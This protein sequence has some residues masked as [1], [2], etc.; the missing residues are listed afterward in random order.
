MSISLQFG[1][2]LI[3]SA[4]I[5]ALAYRRGALSTSGVIGAVVVG[6]AIFGFGGWVWGL[7]L[8]A[9]FVLSS[10]LSHYRM[11]EKARLAAD[12]FEKGSARDIWQALANGGAGALIAAAYALWQPDP[13][14]LAAFVGAMASVN[15]D[16]WATELGVLSRRPPRRITT[17][18]PVEAGASGGVS[19]L[20]TLA[21]LGGALTIG[22]SA[23]LLLVLD[24]LLG[25]R[26]LATAGGPT[27]APALIAAALVGGLGGALFDSVL[28]ASVQAVYFCP[29]CRKETEKRLHTCGTPTVPQRGWRWLGNDMVNFLSSLVG[30]LL[31]Y[32]VWGIIIK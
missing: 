4:L 2:G 31:A 32:G 16:T 13:R 9:F 15:A 8:I 19:L 28:G 24:G 27:E 21:A 29:T 12:K 10:L 3:F 20:G 7:L 30:A 6:T 25:G 5:A 22:V 1:M 17:L 23:L 11:A 26:G 14:L 18:A